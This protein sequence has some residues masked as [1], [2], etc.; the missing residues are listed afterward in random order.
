MDSRSLW[1][2]S[3]ISIWTLYSEY[4]HQSI[5]HFFALVIYKYGNHVLFREYDEKRKRKIEE[6][7]KIKEAAKEILREK[8]FIKR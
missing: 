7:I 4:H 1:Y 5:G 2:T 8:S 6:S 3:A